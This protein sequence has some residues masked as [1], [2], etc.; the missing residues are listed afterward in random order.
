MKFVKFLPVLLL[1]VLTGCASN[2]MLVRKG[3]KIEIAELGKAQVVFMRS[4]FVGGAINASLYDVTNGDIKF[5]G[6]IAND[7]K[8]A[9]SVSP[10]KHRFMVV[11][12]AA[13]FMEAELAAGKTYY[14]IVTPRMG[15][16]KARFSMW[17]IRN[18]NESQ[19]NL[20]SKDF[21]GWLTGT[22]LVENS[23]KS[24]QWYEKNKVSVA[25]KFAE[26]LTVWKQK[27]ANDLAERTLNP[28]D[29]I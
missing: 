28:A 24:L 26:Y 29:G 27:S 4:S 15:F 20:N 8:I 14:S 2:P 12:E 7:T 23:E 10:G 25:N 18:D 5:I 11:S 6:I 1:I 21:K 16:W 13:D 22:D 9:Y 19:Y 3:Q 17:P